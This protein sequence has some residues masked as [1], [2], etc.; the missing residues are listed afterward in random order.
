MA[1]GKEVCDV[2]DTFSKYDLYINNWLCGNGG[3]GILFSVQGLP[4]GDL[5]TCFERVDLCGAVLLGAFTGMATNLVSCVTNT[6]YR[7]SVKHN[8]STRVFQILFGVLFVIIGVLTWHGPVSLLVIGAKVLST[9]ANGINNPKIIRIMNLIIMPMWVIYD[10]VVFSLAGILSDLF[11][12]LS[13]VIAMTRLDRMKN[14]TD[15]CE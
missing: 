8:K 4:K 14:K 3:F 10:V 5:A 2:R 9:V 13:I 1:F 7:V 11:T 6:V 15:S 12:F